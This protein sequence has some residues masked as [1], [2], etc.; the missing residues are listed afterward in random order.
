MAITSQ[1]KTIIL[2]NRKTNQNAQIVKNQMNISL[3]LSS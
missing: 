1:A 3:V 2:L